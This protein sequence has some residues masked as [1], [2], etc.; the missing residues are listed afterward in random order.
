LLIKKNYSI[1]KFLTRDFKNNT[2]SGF[3]FPHNVGVQVDLLLVRDCDLPVD[4]RSQGGTLLS[5][6]QLRC[7]LGSYFGHSV[8]VTI[9][10]FDFFY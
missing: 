3:S 8:L 10:T 6:H 7:Q 4:R 9:F 2:F 5:A 1:P